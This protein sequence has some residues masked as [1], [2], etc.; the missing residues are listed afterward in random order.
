M[1]ALFFFRIFYISFNEKEELLMRKLSK[2]N[3]LDI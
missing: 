2:K 1:L 3:I